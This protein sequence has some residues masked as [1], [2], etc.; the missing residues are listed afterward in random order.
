MKITID[1]TE[2]FI[3]INKLI[4]IKKFIDAYKIIYKQIKINSIIM[5]TFYDTNYYGNYSFEIYYK[6][7]YRYSRFFQPL[8]SSYYEIHK[9]FIKKKRYLDINYKLLSEYNIY[10]SYFIY[11]KYYTY[12]NIKQYYFT[13]DSHTKLI[14]SK[15]INCRDYYRIYSFI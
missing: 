12:D 14:L 9:K 15:I 11:N 8:F 5:Y 2:S 7:N 4:K 6:H 13:N 3:T 1:S 10:Y